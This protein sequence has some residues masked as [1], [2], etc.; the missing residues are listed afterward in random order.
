MQYMHFAV[1]KRDTWKVIREAILSAPLAL[2]LSPKPSD[3]YDITFMAVLQFC[4]HA[5]RANM[6]EPDSWAVAS[7]G[8]ESHS[9]LQF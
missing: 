2:E 5:L 6:F 3:M 4:T 1:T 7:R 9:A 8:T